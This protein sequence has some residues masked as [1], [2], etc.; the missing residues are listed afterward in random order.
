MTSSNP[1]VLRCKI[2]GLGD[3]TTVKFQS[4]YLTVPAT[5]QICT[6]LEKTI[7]DKVI[8]SLGA[9]AF[10]GADVHH[11]RGTLCR[12]FRRTDGQT[13]DAGPHRVS[14]VHQQRAR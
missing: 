1:F 7:E 9:G 8:S 14:R 4:F 5:V 2:K 11:G 3:V 10:A 6:W 12:A 13:G